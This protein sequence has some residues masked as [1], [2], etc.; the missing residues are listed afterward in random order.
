MVSKSIN[1][2]AIIS[3]DIQSSEWLFVLL[4]LIIGDF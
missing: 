2:Q 3:Y 1:N 4:N